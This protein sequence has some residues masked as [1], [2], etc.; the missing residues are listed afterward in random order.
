M[1]V[2]GEGV[3]KIGERVTT[4]GMGVPSKRGMVGQTKRKETKN[5]IVQVSNFSLGHS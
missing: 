2:E 1:G 3:R 4:G 5:Q